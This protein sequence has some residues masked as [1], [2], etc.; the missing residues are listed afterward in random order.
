MGIMYYVKTGKPGSNMPL[1]YI[2]KESHS[3]TESPAETGS[4]MPKIRGDSTSEAL[5]KHWSKSVRATMDKEGL[6]GVDVADRIGVSKAV[7]TDWRS[8]RQL[9]SLENAIAYGRLVREPLSW[10]V[11]DRL[12]G[13]KSFDALGSALAKK[14]GHARLGALMDVPDK[15]LNAELDRIIGANFVRSKK[16]SPGR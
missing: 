4:S 10:L 1:T 8:G 16:K 11:G 14:V 7:V 9:P 2:G 13:K 5:K 12:H 3:V 15:D 6:R